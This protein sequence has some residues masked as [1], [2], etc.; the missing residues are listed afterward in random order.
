MKIHQFIHG[1]AFAAALATTTVGIHAQTASAMPR[2]PC[3]DYI[4]QAR[5]NQALARW[6]V[7]YGKVLLNLGGGSQALDAFNNAE[8]F[9]GFAEAYRTEYDLEHRTV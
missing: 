4:N 5:A 1:V 9:S 3:Q 7:D 2:N 8:V 6:W